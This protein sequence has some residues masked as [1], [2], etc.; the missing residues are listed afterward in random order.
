L[1]GHLFNALGGKTVVIGVA[2]R[3]YEGA[4]AL[5]VL[6][7]ASRAPLLVSAVGIDAIVAAEHVRHMHGNHRMPTM[8]KR[9]DTLSRTR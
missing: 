1:G 5:P 2:K 6:R 3:P 9:A 8:I 4:I 7:G